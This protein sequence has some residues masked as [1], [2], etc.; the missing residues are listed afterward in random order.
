ME[1]FCFI[2]NVPGWRWAGST[3][4][5]FGE[6]VSVHAWQ[7]RGGE[8]KAACRR[9]QP[10]TNDA[11]NGTTRGSNVCTCVELWTQEGSIVCICVVLWSY[12]RSRKFSMRVTV[13]YPN[14][15]V[16]ET[17]SSHSFD[18]QHV[19]QELLGGQNP[20]DADCARCSRANTDLAP[21]NVVSDFKEAVH[22]LTLPKVLPFRR[23]GRVHAW[24]ARGPGFETAC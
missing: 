14:R 5:F 9:S 1:D 21:E 16:E 2:V 15:W 20:D 12:M 3:R 8:F 6:V 23:S 4:H 17:E 24:Q 11:Q 10:V 18:S 19:V 22:V 7:A 13:D